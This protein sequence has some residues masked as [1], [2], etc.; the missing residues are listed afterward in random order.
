MTTTEWAAVQPPILRTYAFPERRR[1]DPI[2]QESGSELQNI[3]LK[4]RTVQ[5]STRNLITCKYRRGGTWAPQVLNDRLPQ[6]QMQTA[7]QEA[8]GTI[9]QRTKALEEFLVVLAEAER[10]VAQRY[11]QSP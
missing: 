10:T 2:P 7:C 5:S 3:T 8:C 1:M 4:V 11:P 9:P 6:N